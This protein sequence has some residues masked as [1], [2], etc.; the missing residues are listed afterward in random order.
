MSC[1]SNCPGC[2]A[3]ALEALVKAAESIDG[4]L[5]TV[6]FT[7]RNEGMDNRYQLTRIE[8]AIALID[9]LKVQYLIRIPST[10]VTISAIHFSSPNT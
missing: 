2:L 3:T 9:N 6:D 4:Q 8:T 5:S 1:K 10:S 7:I